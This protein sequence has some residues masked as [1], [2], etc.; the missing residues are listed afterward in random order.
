ME[1][2][3]EQADKVKKI[4]GEKGEIIDVL[5]SEYGAK[6]AELQKENK[7]LWSL[8]NTIQTLKS[9]L[10]DPAAASIYGEACKALKAKYPVEARF[11]EKKTELTEAIEKLTD[12]KAIS[13]LKQRS[14][15]AFE[16]LLANDG[17]KKS[18]KEDLWN[19]IKGIAVHNTKFRSEQSRN[20]FKS[21]Y[22]AFVANDIYSSPLKK[23]IREKITDNPPAV[24]ERYILWPDENVMEEWDNF[25]KENKDKDEKAIKEVLKRIESGS[26]SPKEVKTTVK[27]T[28]AV[29]RATMKSEATSDVIQKNKIIVDLTE[30]LDATAGGYTEG[31]EIPAD[32][33][34]LDDRGYTAA[35]KNVDQDRLNDLQNNLRIQA[36]SAPDDQK[37]IF[38]KLLKATIEEQALLASRA[39][40]KKE[41]KSAEPLKP[42]TPVRASVVEEPA[43]TPATYGGVALKKGK[44]DDVRE[45][46]LSRVFGVLN[47]IV[48]D[49]DP[50][51]FGEKIE[52]FN[53]S[54]KISTITAEEKNI[55]L[56]SG[57]LPI[58]IEILDTKM[59][60]AR[61]RGLSN[62][63][64]DQLVKKLGEL[65]E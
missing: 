59:V 36:A 50:K 17:E 60:A 7:E 56:G 24:I 46:E 9:E 22:D 63:N 8:R 44:K 43:R 61:K 57:K 62:Q 65:G 40:M 16:A 55:I 6:D 18:L 11:D 64:F 29:R 1:R 20:D 23:F 47:D 5:S 48:T 31:L 15:E 35:L 32:V 38:E 25:Y 21:T 52:N 10:N 37:G 49:F 2:L 33:S 28:M 51:S 53:T 19:A 3:K 26:A 12:T 13:V 54:L 34:K 27:T 58:S 45:Q 39:K 14:K 41:Q 4:S 42:K 30:F